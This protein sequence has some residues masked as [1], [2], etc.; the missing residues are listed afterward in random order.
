LFFIFDCELCR[1]KEEDIK[2]HMVDLLVVV[3]VAV[4]VAVVV[5]V[6]AAV[7]IGRE[8]S[9]TMRVMNLPLYENLKNVLVIKN[10]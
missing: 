7:E 9:R 10:Q 8:R 2:N 5:V 1:D 3:V 4:V 6:P